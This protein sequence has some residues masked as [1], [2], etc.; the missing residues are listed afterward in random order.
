MAAGREVWYSVRRN[1]GLVVDKLSV[2]EDL[3]PYYL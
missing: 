2:P 1:A 3:S